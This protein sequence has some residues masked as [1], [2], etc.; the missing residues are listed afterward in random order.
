MK[1]QPFIPCGQIF[2]VLYAPAPGVIS[3]LRGFAL[4]SLLE[5]NSFNPFGFTFHKIV[6]FPRKAY[7]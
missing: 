2:S 4:K 1:N 7:P 6:H 5:I 3:D